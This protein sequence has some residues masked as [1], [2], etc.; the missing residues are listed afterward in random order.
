MSKSV[1]R[2]Y[3]YNLFYQ[4]L[5]ILTPLIT[6]PYVSRVLEADGVGRLSYIQSVE[7]Y[8]VLLG[9]LG[10]NMYA[11][12]LIAY[13]RGNKERVT[14]IF[15]EI[16]SLKTFTI[17]IT[18][19]F[20]FLL[21]S[22]SKGYRVLFYIQSIDIVANIFDI[23]WLFQGEENFKVT[24]MRNTIIKIIGI[25]M[26]F[27]FVHKKTDLLL[28][29]F[30]L[31]GTGFLGNISLWPHAKQY[32]NKIPIK[33]LK[34]FEH[35]HGTILL[36]IP[37][38]AVQI[39]TVL[40]KTMIQLITKSDYQ[41]GYYEQSQKITKMVLTIVTALGTVMIP[42]I[43]N[44]YSKGDK[45]KINEYLNL[46]FRFVWFLGLPM[47]LG[48][49]AVAPNLV[50]WFFGKGYEPVINLIRVF[51]IL[52]L[53]IG[54]NNVTGMQYLLPTGQEKLF[55]KTV[56]VGSVANFG[57]NIFL[58]PNYKAAG[59]AFASVF[60]E[61]LITAVQFWYL[62]KDI[63]VLGVF[64]ISKNY[65]ISGIIMFVPIYFISLKLNPSLVN[66]SLIILIGIVFYIISL[67][68]L[69]DKFLLQIFRKITARNKVL[70]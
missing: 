42:R 59:A 56:I 13:S 37:Q 64:K 68:L 19:V 29:A 24:V 5:I 69:K 38:I 15:W 10:I 52:I 39:Y 11:Q 27:L 66:T 30:I 4:I 16:M 6:A 8:F 35:V 62:R 48:L 14:K 18:L 47:M 61:S 54:I 65:L 60:G 26:I 55:T 25:I 43:A 20:Y 12:R 33:S 21:T 50:P 46:A 22:M 2:N 31:Y 58:I 23:S 63:D 49:F 9:T 32:L 36:F 44:L 70:V 7:A 1:A 45:K 17:A 3:G 40:D 51:S 34:P 53:A 57:L 41:N 67:L 28:Y